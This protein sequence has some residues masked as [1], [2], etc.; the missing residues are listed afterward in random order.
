VGTLQWAMREMDN[1]YKRLADLGARNINEYNRKVNGNGRE[2]MPF[3]VIVI[4]ELADLM[5]LSP[6]ET[7][8]G[9][10]RLA[11]MAR[12]TGIHMVIA[13]Q[14][15]SVDVVTGLIKA[16]FPARIAFAVASST[17]SRVILDT[18]G[19]ERLLG[20]GDM[21]FQSPD[22]AAPIRMQGCFV[23][24]GELNKLIK[25][26]Q[27]AVR[28]SSVA[29]TPPAGGETP[30]E[31]AETGD[32]AASDRPPAPQHP[33]V[34]EPVQ[35]PLWEELQAQEE[36]AQKYEDE[37]LPDAIA[38]VRQL[39]K[40]S[41]SLLQRRFRIGYTR[42]ARMMDVMEEDGIIGPP[43]GTSKAREVLPW[44]DDKANLDGEN[45]ASQE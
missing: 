39:G 26:W 42:A 1:R 20:Q 36:E 37:L 28:F 11:Q 23:S 25:Y 41:T 19:A 10:T 32:D 15:P 14:R 18:T 43:T 2:P 12:A 44:R 9:I 7:E 27:S 24:E 5:M 13:T 40:A 29:A 3:I 4:D 45:G 21:L 38:L 16:N 17:D 33:P 22:A 6:D 31:A 35:Q 34:E 8:R 30:A